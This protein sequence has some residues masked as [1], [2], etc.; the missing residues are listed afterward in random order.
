MTITIDSDTGPAAAAL[1]EAAK[2]FDKAPAPDAAGRFSDLFLR[3]AAVEFVRELLCSLLEHDLSP[4]DVHEL[5]DIAV[6]SLEGPADARIA[7]RIAK[8]RRRLVE[9]IRAEWE[10]D[11]T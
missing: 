6:D 7:D 1:R 8:F 4:I 9:S 11:A 10:G 5:H 3:R 2:L